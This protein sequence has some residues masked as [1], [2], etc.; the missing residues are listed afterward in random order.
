MAQALS[1]SGGCVLSA[2]TDDFSVDIDALHE[3][4]RAEYQEIRA[5]DDN[6]DISEEELESLKQQKEEIIAAYEEIQ[7]EEELEYKEGSTAALMKRAR[8]EFT[9]RVRQ[10]TFK[11]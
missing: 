6:D 8:K 2:L 4:C 9:M 1:V 7:G 11:V 10:C 5:F 3:Q